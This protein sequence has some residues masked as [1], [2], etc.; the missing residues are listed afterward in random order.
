MFDSPN[1]RTR[2]D[3]SLCC[4]LPRNNWNMCQLSCYFLRWWKLYQFSFSLMRRVGVMTRQIV[5][6]GLWNALKRLPKS[7]LRTHLHHHRA[8]PLEKY[9]FVGSN[10]VFHNVVIQLAS[11]IQAGHYSCSRSEMQFAVCQALRN[12]IEHTR[13]PAVDSE[14]I[15]WVISPKLQTL[16]IKF[17]FY[18]ALLLFPWLLHYLL[19][20]V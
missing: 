4:F 20:L 19:N 18:S 10:S 6:V 7:S 3:V 9:M 17:G 2:P 5:Y 15:H 16:F 14:T 11:E 1:Y 8:A 12:S 13:C